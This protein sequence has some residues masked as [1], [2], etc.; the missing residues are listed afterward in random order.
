VVE[1][2]QGS[3]TVTGENATMRRRLAL[4]LACLVL[5]GC[6]ASAAPARKGPCSPRVA[7][8]AGPGTRARALSH[9]FELVTCSYTDAAAAFRVTVDTAPQAWVRWQRAEVERTQTTAEWA[10]IPD[11][12]PRPVSGVGG[13]A[14]WIRAT[15]E[16]VASDGRELLTVRVL[17][18]AAGARAAAI[19]VAR[20]ALGPVRLPTG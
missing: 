20:A 15:R 5:A 19:R 17:H 2:A 11:Q 18:P 1:D 8:A 16:L 7:A 13:G 6:G 12:Q 3:F 4:G 9:E 14:F 10:R